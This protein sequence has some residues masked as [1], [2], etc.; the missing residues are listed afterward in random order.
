M[1]LFINTVISETGCDDHSELEVCMPNG[2]KFTQ[3]EQLLRMKDGKKM[4][5][6]SK[7]LVTKNVAIGFFGKT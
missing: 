3:M 6:K 1:I 7:F 2:K 5:S 4:G